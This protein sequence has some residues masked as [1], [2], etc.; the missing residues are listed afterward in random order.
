MLCAN[1]YEIIVF[2]NGVRS[3]GGTHGPGPSNDAS[4]HGHVRSVH[5]WWR[6]P[7]AEAWVGPRPG[8][9]YRGDYGHL[10]R[11]SMRASPFA[12]C[13]LMLTGLGNAMCAGT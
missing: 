12:A 4:R 9:G 1:R 2:G 6:L 10:A 13:G 3:G 8:H 5:L 11:V 7:G